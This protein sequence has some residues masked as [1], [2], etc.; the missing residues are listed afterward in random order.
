MG[1]K[2]PFRASLEFLQTCIKFT[3]A[4][5][6][7]SCFIIY[8]GP[9]GLG[10]Q[11]ERA[12]KLEENSSRPHICLFFVISSC[13]LK[14]HCKAVDSPLSTLLYAQIKFLK[15]LGSLSEVQPLAY[16]VHNGCVIYQICTIHQ[17]IQLI[18]V[19]ITHQFA[20]LLKRKQTCVFNSIISFI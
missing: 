7:V 16:Q 13:F 2:T 4:D 20:K 8:Q 12:I 10:M 18:A 3:Y 19:V 11:L 9:L 6:Q 15:S 5:C 17:A 1:I 14:Y